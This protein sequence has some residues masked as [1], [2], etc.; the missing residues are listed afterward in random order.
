MALVLIILKGSPE[1]IPFVTE[2]KCDSSFHLVG[3]GRLLSAGPKC[4][5]PWRQGQS[6]LKGTGMRML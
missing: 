2:Q 4:R 1:P 3:E 5:V 6:S